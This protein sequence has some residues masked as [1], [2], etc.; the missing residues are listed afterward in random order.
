MAPC[1]ERLAALDELGH[2]VQRFD[3][4]HADAV[5]LLEMGRESVPVHRRRPW[6]QRVW[7]VALSA[8]HR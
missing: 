4:C 1:A 6:Y 5:T 7:A 8:R 3:T 2:N